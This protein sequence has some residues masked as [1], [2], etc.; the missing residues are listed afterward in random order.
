MYTRVY[1]DISTGIYTYIVYLLV[2]MCIHLNR[3]TYLY[4][5]YHCHCPPTHTHTYIQNTHISEPIQNKT[6]CCC[7]S[8]YITV[9]TYINLTLIYSSVRHWP[10]MF[11]L[12]HSSFLYFIMSS[13]CPNL[14]CALESFLISVQRIK[15]LYQ[16]DWGGSFKPLSH[17]RTGACVHRVACRALRPEH[18]EFPRLIFNPFTMHHPHT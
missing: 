7:F 1:L 4:T 16:E 12:D 6:C 2:S 9:L 14:A 11:P 8:F 10:L 5:N 17:G 15:S 3:Y 18:P 13:P